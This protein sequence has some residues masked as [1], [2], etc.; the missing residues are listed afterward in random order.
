[1][2]PS[3]LDRQIQQNVTYFI[4]TTLLKATSHTFKMVDSL[5]NKTQ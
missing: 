5:R 3:F 1:M 4:R 2:I